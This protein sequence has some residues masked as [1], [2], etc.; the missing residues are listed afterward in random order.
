MTVCADCGVLVRC[1]RRG[2]SRR[3][4]DACRLQHAKTW[5]SRQ[6]GHYFKCACGRARANGAA[7]CLACYWAEK[8]REVHICQ[9]CSLSFRPIRSLSKASCQVNKYCSRACYFAMKRGRA[10][11]RSIER[12]I[13]Q[14]HA[15]EQRKRNWTQRHQERQEQRAA[16]RC[17]C[18]AALT[19]PTARWCKNCYATQ[20][21][22]GIRK[23]REWMRATGLDHLCPNCG[24]WFKGYE[25]ST[26]CS[27]KCCTQWKPGRYPCIS[28][29]PIEERNQLAELLALVREANRRMQHG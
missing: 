1:P 17:P 26:F 11:T 2:P 12:K 8:R 27:L 9:Q 22:N 29:V 16:T 3:R 13:A 20:I 10:E 4:C 7:R 24:Q 5:P 19:R 18:G 15:R 25:S 21:G 14:A 6:P 23:G 28:R